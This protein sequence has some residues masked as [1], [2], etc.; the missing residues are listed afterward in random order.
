MPDDRGGKAKPL[1]LWGVVCLAFSPDGQVLAAGEANAVF[2]RA[3]IQ[4]YDAQTAKPKQEAWDIGEWR[5]DLGHVQVI[6]AA[7]GKNLVSA[8]GPVKVW[9]VRTGKVLRT[10]DTQGLPS[11][12]V[13]VSRRHVAISG[14]RQE[15]D[16]FI[17]EV[18][19][20]DATTGKL[21]LSLR[22]PDRWGTMSLA[23]SPDGASLAIG[24]STGSPDANVKDSEKTVKGEVKIVPV[25][26]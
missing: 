19:M 26:G 5:R 16:S 21:E 4:L 1:A 22:W 14:V 25:G 7:D 12:I 24:G 9:D 18:R 17:A 3:R 6:F 8:S 13:A 2:Q 10:L 20:W 15:K 11:S 23:F